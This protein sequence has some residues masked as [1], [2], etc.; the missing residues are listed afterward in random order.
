VEGENSDATVADIGNYLFEH[1]RMGRLG[2]AGICDDDS[3]RR[4]C[5]EVV[6]GGVEL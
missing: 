4:G 5:R 1:G 3:G 6:E 2:D